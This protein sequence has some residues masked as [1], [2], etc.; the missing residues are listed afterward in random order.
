MATVDRR[1]MLSFLLGGAAAATAGFALISGPAESA[2]FFVLK[3]PDSEPEHPV[4]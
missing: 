2:P 1:G 3:D 4:D